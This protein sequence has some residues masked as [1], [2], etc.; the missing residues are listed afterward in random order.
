[1]RY[2]IYLG[3]TD[4]YQTINKTSSLV[5]LAMS[6]APG[7]VTAADE[8]TDPSKAPNISNSI[9]L[10][11]TP[12]EIPVTIQTIT[13]SESVNPAET[14]NPAGV[15]TLGEAQTNN[16]SPN[17]SNSQSDNRETGGSGDAQVNK[18]QVSSGQVDNNWMK[19]LAA[20]FAKLDKT[21]N[22]LVIPSEATRGKAFNKKS[23][24][25]AY[26]YGSIDQNE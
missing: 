17:P 13:P 21:G 15:A 14:V 2:L 1:M 4:E 12:A 7:L 26:T 19:P 5:L 10:P 9:E 18:G 8:M 3:V 6:L 24:A 25:K 16:D 23:F 11:A 22:D 20:E